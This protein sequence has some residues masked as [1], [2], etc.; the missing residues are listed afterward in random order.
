MSID[1]RGSAWRARYRGP[2]GRQIQRS[3]GRKID[4]ERWLTEQRS[5][6]SRGEWVDPAASRVKFGDV[7]REWL[8]SARHLKP[9]TRASY[10]SLLRTPVLPVW[11]KVPLG[12]IA[13]DAVADW[14][15]SMVAAGMSSSRIR[16]AVFVLSATCDY[17]IRSD[18]LVR[19]PAKGVKLPRVARK[20]GSGVP[21][22]RPGGRVGRS[23]AG[24]LSA[25]RADIGLH[26]FAVG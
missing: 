3:F 17:A 16:Q 5:R 4:A 25:V 26:G 10:M 19:N 15:K 22:S 2:D 6:Q 20:G 12:K 13:H 24:T 23:Y 8:R 9:K 7:A 1:K 21:G 11:E 14:V 18:R